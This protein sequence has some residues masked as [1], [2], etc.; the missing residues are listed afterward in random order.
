MQIRSRR[1]LLSPSTFK[2]EILQFE[3]AVAMHGGKLQ[4]LSIF[5]VILHFVKTAWTWDVSCP[6]CSI[7]SA[8]ILEVPE[9][10][11]TLPARQTLFARNN[12]INRRDDRVE[13]GLAVRHIEIVTGKFYVFFHLLPMLPV[14][15]NYIKRISSHA[16][17]E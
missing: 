11:L 15:H 3:E 10:I 7:Q 2:N 13:D 1:F 6:N 9:E 12:P 14:S 17:L 8:S 5:L 16:S 4:L